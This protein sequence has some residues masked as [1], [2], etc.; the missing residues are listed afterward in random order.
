MSRFWSKTAQSIIPYIP[1]EQPR[2]RKY[3]KLNTNENPYPP[4]LKVYDAIRDANDSSIR[5]YP[6]PDATELKSALS[7]YYK[8][9]TDEVFV[10]NGSD[11]VLAFC[12]PAFFNREDVIYFPDVTYSFYP[13][14]AELFGVEYKTVRLN[15]DFTVPLDDFPKSARGIFLANPNAPAGIALDAD[16]IEALVRRLPDTLIIV[17]EAYVDFGAQSVVGITK[18]YDNLLVVQTFS[19]SRQMAGLRVGFAIGNR[20]L[21]EGLER[22]KN[23]FNS[24]T[25]DRIAQKAAVAAIEDDGY[26]R[27]TC[28][29][30]IRTRD[31]TSK[32]LAELGFKVLPSRANFLFVSHEKY[33]GKDLFSALKKEGILVRHFPKSGIDNWLRVTIGTDEEMS[34]LIEKLKGLVI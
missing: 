4:S 9:G 6:D 8:I 14:Y 34:I 25:L 16:E 10:G 24:Y 3:I 29:K 22:I 11:E 7:G 18:K 12:F 26:F 1:G 2:D 17:D 5:L 32:K 28:E 33:S 23:S 21:I 19:K 13:V 20:G 15:S 30:I 31:D 27:E